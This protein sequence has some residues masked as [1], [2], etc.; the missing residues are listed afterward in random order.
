M[1]ML[2]AACLAATA[3]S[4]SFA[5]VKYVNVSLATGANDGTSWENAYR[6]PQ[7]LKAA[8]DAAVT[9]DEVWVAKGTYTASPSTRNV[10]HV[11]KLGVAVYGGF[12]GTETAIAQRDWATNVTVI[13]GDLLGND[14]ATVASRSDN[15][16]HLVT[17]G[18]G[19]TQS[20]DGFTLSGGNANGASATNL[21][22][23]G[24]IICLASQSPTFRNCRFFDNRC[25]FGG[26]AGY[27]LNSS[28]KFFDCSFENNQGGSFGGAFDSANGTQPTFERCVFKGNKAI[29]AGALEFFGGS[30]PKVTNCL[31]VGNQ[32]TGSGG[33]GAI[34]L[35]S[36]SNGTFRNI[37]VT[38]NSATVVGGGIYNT[39]GTSTFA[40]VISFGNT[41]P[42]TVADN[43][44]KSQG[45]TSTITYSCVQGIMSGTGNINLDPKF[46]DAPN[47][48][49]RLSLASPCIDAGNN[50]SVPAGVTVDLDGSARF[51]DQPGVVDTGAG[52]APIVDMG[53][54]ELPFQAPACPTDLDGDGITGASDLGLLLGAWSTA[55]ADLDGDGTTGASDLGI[56]LGA[57]GDC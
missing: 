9:G 37:T 43:G 50:A 12:A 39:G 44:I 4:P 41:G 36:S 11:L 34:W 55:G 23:G 31:F 40:N 35:G 7:A 22:K 32:A 8:M 28:P 52:T 5:A 48:D 51:V 45:G 56:L 6:G 30:Q 57:W 20:L 16:Y 33:G 54:Y 46:A 25:T 2:L 26:G 42:G 53:A 1:R 15:S 18:T 19:T 3:V 24:A 49:Y 21:D 14:D 17:S 38:G 29:R 27:L 10:S 47:A 13:S